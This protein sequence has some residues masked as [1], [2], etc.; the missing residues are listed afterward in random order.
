MK[1]I[2]IQSTPFNEYTDFY[3]FGVEPYSKLLDVYYQ[4][5]QFLDNAVL[6]VNAFGDGQVKQILASVSETR[7]NYQ[8]VAKAFL[9]LIALIPL[10]AILLFKRLGYD[11]NA[12]L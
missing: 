12:K 11:L 6:T 5:S 2:K 9:F 3:S 8:V 7:G 4:K 10:A 1:K